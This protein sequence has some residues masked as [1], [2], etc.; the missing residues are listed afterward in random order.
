MASASQAGGPVRSWRIAPRLGH[1]LEARE[2][3]EIDETLGAAT[4]PMDLSDEIMRW[5]WKREGKS[6]WSL[7]T[8][9]R[10]F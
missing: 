3:N 10:F 5:Q 2:T 7:E 9:K 8:G 1:Q 6:V 4:Y